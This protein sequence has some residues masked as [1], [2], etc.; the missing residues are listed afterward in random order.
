MR[1]A[2]RMALGA[3]LPL[4][5]LAVAPPASAEETVCGTVTDDW[6]VTTVG[7][8]AANGINDAGQIAGERTTDSSTR[9]G[10]AVVWDEGEVTE[11]GYLWGGWLRGRD[12]RAHDVDDQGRVVGVSSQLDGNVH[13]FLWENGWMKDLGAW[14]AQSWAQ[15]VGGGH[16]GGYQEDP[17][18]EGNYF[19]KWHA[20]TWTGGTRSEL[21]VTPGSQVID[22]NERGDAVG[23]HKL[24]DFPI[25]GPQEEIAHTAFARIGGTVHD[26]GTVGGKWSIANGVNDDGLV[27]GQSAT[28]AGGVYRTGF[29]WTAGKGMRELPDYGVTGTDAAAVNNAGE[30][31]GWFACPSGR[32]GVGVWPSPTSAPLFLPRPAGGERTWVTDINDRGDIVGTSIYPEGTRAVL[33]RKKTTG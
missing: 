8:N 29:A 23:V 10:V 3:A 16:V 6:T 13:A 14:G 12:S 31:A 25:T 22:V 21:P 2:V 9:S 26:L 24:V 17:A 28:D 32:S 5:L 30:I 18:Y 11:L 15:A 4:S 1:T 27:V 20:S 7:I 19:Q 33:W